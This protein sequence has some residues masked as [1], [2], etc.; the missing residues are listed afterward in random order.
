MLK[1]AI[2]GRYAEALY[3]VAVREDAVDKIENELKSINEVLSSSPELKKILF[4]PR[5]TAAEKRE[6]LHNL[7]AGRVSELTL[8]FL[9]VVVDHRREAFIEDMVLVFTDMANKARNVSDVQVTSAVELTDDERERLL[10]VLEGATGK[11]IRA[12]YVVDPSLIGGLVVRI[13][14]RIIDGSVRTRLNALREQLRQI[15]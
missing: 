15:S 6:V 13:G 2:A 12:S 4:H 11:K 10:K 14:D 8:N 5:I 1:G 9:D 3:E 7:F